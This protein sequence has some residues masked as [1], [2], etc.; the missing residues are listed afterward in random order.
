MEPFPKK[1]EMIEIDLKDDPD[2]KKG[3]FEIGDKIIIRGHIFKVRKITKK[4]LILRHIG[5]K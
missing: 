2:F 3:F 5:R 1:E 4:D